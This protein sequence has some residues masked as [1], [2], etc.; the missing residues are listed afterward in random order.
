MKFVRK[1]FLTDINIT[2][3]ENIIKYI[4]SLCFILFLI[5]LLYIFSRPYKQENNLYSSFKVI[6]IIFY[7]IG[8]SVFMN[9]IL[10]Y[11]KKY[12]KL[13]INGI[14][15]ENIDKEDIYD[16]HNQIYII[17]DTSVTIIILILVYLFISQVIFNDN[18]TSEF[19]NISQLSEYNSSH[20]IT[21]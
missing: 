17:S 21:L 2:C 4:T 15:I 6:I 10:N 12:N 3:N 11:I 1:S 9:K 20:L 16:D 13:I 18:N 7:C 5:I 8:F 14:N 19:S